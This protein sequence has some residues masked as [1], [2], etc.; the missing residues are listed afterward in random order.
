MSI[1]FYSLSVYKIEQAQRRKQ[2]I[3]RTNDT[4]LKCYLHTVL[5]SEEGSVSY[6]RRKFGLC[7]QDAEKAKTSKERLC[8]NWQEIQLNI[9]QDMII[10]QICSK[11]Q[12]LL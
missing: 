11:T 6:F 7:F 5:F 9:T 1:F 2:R 8:M 12:L 4:E 3:T 10:V